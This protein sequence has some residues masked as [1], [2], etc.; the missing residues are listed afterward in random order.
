M[1]RIVSKK[2][3]MKSMRIKIK[4]YKVPIININFYQ[5]YKTKINNIHKN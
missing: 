1:I 5:I 4:I 2:F 3:K